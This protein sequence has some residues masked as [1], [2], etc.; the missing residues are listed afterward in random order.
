MRL[1]LAAFA[2]CVLSACALSAADNSA[3][4]LVAAA[5]GDVPRINSLLVQGASVESADKNGRTPLMLAAQHGHTPAVKALL[6]AGANADA[7]DRGGLNAFAIALL[8]PAGRGD[9][10]GVLAALPRPPRFRLA[11]VTG[12]APSGLISSCFEPR[13]ALLQRVALLRPDESLLR[14]LQAFIRASGRGLAE[15]VSVDAR[16]VES[17]TAPSSPAVPAD[18]VL[19]LEFQPGSACSGAADSLTFDIDMQV[20]SAR[21]GHP[22]APSVAASKTCAQP[23]SPTPRNTARS[24]RRG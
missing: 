17:L 7:R 22:L 20:L 3:D 4:L 16:N 15:L 1:L 14:E 11:A 5:K 21:D 19:L 8:D 23:Q 12:W 18:A 24:S 13:N 6:A 2:V 10:D 9:R